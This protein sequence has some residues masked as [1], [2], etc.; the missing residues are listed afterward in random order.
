[1]SQ[2]LGKP[3]HE[4]ENITLHHLTLNPFSEL[5]YGS[6]KDDLISHDILNIFISEFQVT[7]RKLQRAKE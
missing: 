1:M 4:V 6:Q 7:S 5:H 2:R 3:P